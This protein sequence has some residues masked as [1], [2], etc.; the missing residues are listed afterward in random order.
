MSRARRSRELCYCF[1]LLRTLASPYIVDVR[2]T[3]DGAYAVTAR[4]KGEDTLHSARFST[5]LSAL[6]DICGATTP[7]LYRDYGCANCLV[8]SATTD[9]R[10]LRAALVDMVAVLAKTRNIT[11]K[12]R[13]KAYT[14][15][16]VMRSKWIRA[17]R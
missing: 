5:L 14:A 7:S 11:L 1:A 2:L 9:A 13:S 6:C 4:K 3:L 15:A 10:P 8:A 17:R 16:A 12:S